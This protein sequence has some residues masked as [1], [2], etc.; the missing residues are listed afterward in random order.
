MD[1]PE[2]G[3]KGNPMRVLWDTTKYDLRKKGLSREEALV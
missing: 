1:S 2:K 3:M